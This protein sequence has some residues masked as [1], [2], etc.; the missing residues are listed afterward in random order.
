M[1]TPAFKRSGD[2]DETNNNRRGHKTAQSTGG[3][4]AGYTT[5]DLIALRDRLL[6]E[7]LDLENRIVNSADGDDA[8]DPAP[9]RTKIDEIHQE[10][11]LRD[12]AERVGADSKRFSSTV[13][14][15]PARSVSGLAE[16][17][18]Q[19]SMQIL[20]AIETR[21]QFMDELA[22]AARE[23]GR[24]DQAAAFTL[25]AQ[26]LDMERVEV[27]RQLSALGATAPDTED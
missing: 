24:L 9:V 20:D 6:E 26:K 11:A 14:E 21:S 27:L 10:L 16:H 7:C 23:Q 8:A 1:A 18:A 22:Q 4:L 12:L 2:T 13:G 3:G 5:A 17:A 19:K 15:R 25:N